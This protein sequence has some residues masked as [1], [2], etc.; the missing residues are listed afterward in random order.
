M[1]KI[2]NLTGLVFGNLTVDRLAT[3]EIDH[4]GSDI[5]WWCSCCCGNKLI[6]RA[7]HLVSGHTKSCRHCKIPSN[8]ISLTMNEKVLERDLNSIAFKYKNIPMDCDAIEQS[9]INEM[10]NLLVDSSV[11]EEEFYSIMKF[12]KTFQEDE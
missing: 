5:R 11:D 4:Q 2:K 3:K 8:F 7:C 9:Y 1:G 6:V 12:F 10:A